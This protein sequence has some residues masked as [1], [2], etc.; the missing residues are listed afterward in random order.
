MAIIGFLPLLACPDSRTSQPRAGNNFPFTNGLYI[1]RGSKHAFIR[2]QSLALHLH[3]TTAQHL[4][5]LTS[6]LE[7]DP[8]NL[9]LLSDTASAAFD[10][11]QYDRCEILLARAEQLQPL[12]ATL[13]NLKG[14][15]ALARSQYASATAAF[16]Q[17]A[18]TYPDDFGVRYNLAYAKTMS[19][20]YEGAANLL[21]SRTLEAVLQAPALK[22]RVLHY[23][24]LLDEAAELGEQ[25]GNRPNADNTLY[26]ALA[27][28]ALDRNQPDIARA[29]ALRAPT[30]AESLTTLGMLTLQ[31]VNSSPAVE[32]FEQALERNPQSGRAW[33][34]KGLGLLLGGHLKTAAGSLD[35]GANI[36]KTHLGTWVAAGWAHLLAG[37]F[38]QAR[39]DFNTALEIDPNF[40]ETHGSLAVLEIKEGNTEAAQRHATISLRLNSKCLSGALAQSLLQTAR[41]N[42]QSGQ[43]ILDKALNTPLNATGMTIA[44]AIARQG[45]K[46][47]DLK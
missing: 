7:Q 4:E 39:A 33:V 47:P 13:T 37:S 15:N 36:M 43:A 42:A 19:G 45:F 3:S 29:Y 9:Q 23:L 18:E 5:R 46:L 20:D 2:E 24:G 26:A 8:S 30:E 27:T 44:Q 14:L 16:S 10:S 1:L 40:A 25:Y 12:S 31:D 32:L 6:Y 28:L 17:L 35:H 11:Q 22:V 21:D 38:D 34:G 41:G